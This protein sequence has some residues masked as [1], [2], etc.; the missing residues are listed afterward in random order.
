MPSKADAAK[1]LIQAVS[2][3]DKGEI[4][5]DVLLDALNST[6]SKD[7]LVLS[8][9]VS[10]EMLYPCRAEIR[11]V[12]SCKVSSPQDLMKWMKDN[13]K[14]VGNERNPQGLKIPPLFVWRSR[15]SDKESSGIF[16][17]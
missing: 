13:I 8:P 5:M 10:T 15:M 16:L 6:D 2:P 4:G 14:I 1:V 3:K 7:P 11:K 17:R 12:L 9:R